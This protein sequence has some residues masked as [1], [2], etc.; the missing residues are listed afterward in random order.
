MGM[1]SAE[2]REYARTH[3]SSGG[4]IDDIGNEWSP[5]DLAEGVERTLAP[6]TNDA[7]RRRAAHSVATLS[8][9]LGNASPRTIT[10]QGKAEL[11]GLFSTFVTHQVQSG[12]F[13]SLEDGV[14]G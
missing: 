13:A 9:M 10:R 4:S 1:N 8:E 14:R 5:Q 7:M 2:G 6:G 3:S 11:Q 12:G